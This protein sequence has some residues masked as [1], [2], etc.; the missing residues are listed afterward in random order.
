MAEQNNT[1]HDRP[2]L[3]RPSSELATLLFLALPY[4]APSVRHLAELGFHLLELH[5]L[6]KSREGADFSS[7]FSNSLIADKDG[8][9]S[10]LKNGCDEKYRPM[11]EMLANFSQ[12]MQFYQIYQELMPLLQSFGMPTGTG[13]SVNPTDFLGTNNPLTSMLFSNLSTGNAQN[14]I[15]PEGMD[16]TQLAS[17]FSTF[18]AITNSSSHSDFTTE[19][20]QKTAT[21]NQCNNQ[22][23]SSFVSDNFSTSDIPSRFSN[24]PTLDTASS[25]NN[26]SA[27][28][29]TSTPD[30][31]SSLK[32]FS[33]SDTTS[34]SNSSYED[35]LALLSPEQKELFEQL[36][37]MF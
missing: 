31:L 6:L 22:N 17:L 23:N 20:I 28:N 27:S 1:T 29:T 2:N 33:D 36:Q 8:L 13:N 7:L 24:S 26:S 34:R 19:G 5:H 11:F 12:I 35:L 30:N 25:L 21:R 16:F 15:L 14:G 37:G 4:L 3:Y 9:L 10:S 32:N 18:S